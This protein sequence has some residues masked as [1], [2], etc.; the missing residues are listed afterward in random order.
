[1]AV[2]ISSPR[3]I[4]GISRR[5]VYNTLSD[6]NNI[7]TLLDQ[8]KIKDRADQV[9]VVNS[10]LC[11]LS[12]DK[13]G[14]LKLAIIERKPIESVSLAGVDTP[15]PIEIELLLSEGAD[16]STIL[17]VQLQVELNFIFKQMLGN[18]LQEAVDKL[19]E[20]FTKLPYDR[21]PRD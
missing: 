20:L 12:I 3:E 13:L 9:E 4:N 19:A 2:Y 1:M 14:K 8:E 17:Q 10:D 6:L 16:M 7:T 21:F 5:Q 11:I 15:I 18:R